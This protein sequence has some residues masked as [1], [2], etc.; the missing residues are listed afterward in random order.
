MDEPFDLC[1]DSSEAFAPR[2]RY[3]RAHRA[4]MEW[5]DIDRYDSGSHSRVRAWRA[6]G[7]TFDE[8]L[9]KLGLDPG[10]PEVAAGVE[11][12]QRPV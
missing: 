11:H 6:D 1:D 5:L 9:R 7:L 4:M 10:D 12:A 2:S 8:V 3:H